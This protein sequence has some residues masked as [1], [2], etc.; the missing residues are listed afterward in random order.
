MGSETIAF[1]MAAGLIAALNPCG[2]AL[3]PGYLA[4]V[5]AGEGDAPPSRIA[6]VG[7]ALAATAMMA[8]GFLVVF[9]SFALILA[10]FTAVIQQYLPVFTVVIGTALLLLGIWMLTGREV[11]LLLPKSRSGAPTA[12]LGSMFGYGVAYAVASL[13]CTIGPFLAVTGSTFRTGSILD[14]IFAYLAYAA[15]MALLVGVLATAIALAAAPVTKWLREATG[16][17]TRIGGALLVAAGAYVSYYGV[18]EL[19]L[20][21]GGDASDPIIEAAARIQQVMSSAVGAVGILPIVILLVV[22]VGV[23]GALGW[24]RAV[25][26]SNAESERQGASVTMT[27][28]G[29]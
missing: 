19:R 2:F 5:V 3:L 26:R 7:R 8:A 10:P 6:A 12:R 16:Y 27:E 11:T 13:S 14:G 15:G 29:A 21:R 23:A 24:R 1:A 28:D 25:G 18:Y 17:L 20:N 22:I 4:L 9:G